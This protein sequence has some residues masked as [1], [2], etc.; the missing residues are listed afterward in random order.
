MSTEAIEITC[1][2][3]ECRVAQTGKCVEGLAFDKCPHIARIAD[4]V[5]TAAVEDGALVAAS[6]LP[7]AELQLPKSERLDAA[8][9]T[10]LMRTAPSRLIAIVGP[11][12]SGKTSLIASLCNLFQKGAVEHLAFGRCKTFFAFEQ[13]C[14][15]ARAASRR[16]TPQTE[17]THLGSGVGF[18]HLGLVS[19]GKLIQLFLSDRPGEDY[20]SV[21][22]D[23]D[24]ASDFTEIKRADSIIIMVNGELL[25]DLTLRHNARTDTLMILQGLK[26]GEVLSASQRLA[27][28][29][30]KLDAIQTADPAVRDRALRD[31]DGIVNMIRARFDSTFQ[32][33]LP[34]RIAASPKTEVLPYA[35]GS[36][37]L[38]KFWV[39]PLA[40]TEPKLEVGLPSARF[41]GRFGMG[42]QESA[43]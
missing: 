5:N 38:L 7:V 4:T 9:A 28:V 13:A 11:T 14:H 15:H 33:I 41:I 23:P 37:E 43:S 40:A 29:L 20:R 30:T 42:D 32:E 6:P 16:S 21:A 12:S 1:G 36:D 3:S 25:L 35:F 19:E 31:F 22:D 10:A 18:Y 26:D 34:F 17:H 24:N 8:E 2:N 39:E 27:I